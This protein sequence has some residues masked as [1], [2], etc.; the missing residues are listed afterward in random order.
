MAHEPYD[1]I[2]NAP[3]RDQQSEDE[4]RK[5]RR[6]EAEDIRYLMKN[7][8]GRRIAWRWLSDAG[9]FKT[10]MTGNS[11]TFFNEGQRNVGLKLLAAIHEHCP[12]QY[13]VMVAES[14]EK[15]DQ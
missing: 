2:R 13:A 15:A 7:K 6:A 5:Q 11:Y 9:V 8:Q 4:R 3:L 14:K 12:E 10:S 1:E